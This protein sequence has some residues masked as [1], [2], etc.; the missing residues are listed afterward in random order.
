MVDLQHAREWR[1]LNVQFDFY[2][3]LLLS[4]LFIPSFLYISFIPCSSIYLSL[5]FMAASLSPSL[6]QHKIADIK[7]FALFITLFQCS[8]DFHILHEPVHV[9][10]HSLSRHTFS[11]SLYT[12]TLKL[13]TCKIWLWILMPNV[14]FATHFI[15]MIWCISERNRIFNNRKKNVDQELIF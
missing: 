13:I 9:W 10:C 6:L 11:L 15:C 7:S 8:N 4:P 5:I 1:R 3:S 14:T 12:E 2:P